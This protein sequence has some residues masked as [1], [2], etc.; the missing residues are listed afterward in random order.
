MKFKNMFFLLSTP[1]IPVIALTSCS[2]VDENA[3][4]KLETTVFAAKNESSF[5]NIFNLLDDQ[6]KIENSFIEKNTEQINSS[7]QKTIDTDKKIQ[8][9]LRIFFFKSIYDS[10]YS[11]ENIIDGVLKPQE[12][13]GDRLKAIE[14][15]KKFIIKSSDENNKFKLLEDELL[16]IVDMKL[17]L[18]QK[19]EGEIQSSWVWEMEFRLAENS[20]LAKIIQG[21]IDPTINKR[22]VFYKRENL[23]EEEI[24]FARAAASKLVPNTTTEEDKL[25]WKEAYDTEI[26]QAQYQSSKWYW[27]ND[28]KIMKTIKLESNI[29]PYSKDGTFGGFSDSDSKRTLFGIDFKQSANN[30]NLYKPTLLFQSKTV[31][32]SYINSDWRKFLE[33][34][35]YLSSSESNNTSEADEEKAKD[36]IFDLNCAN[37]KYDK[38]I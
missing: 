19:N 6:N 24:I 33:Y 14:E 10:L 29:N 8:E 21:N 17:I 28:T 20:E 31:V 25:K 2:A 7:V 32:E 38:K 22:G 13:F 12:A 30:F 16:K 36:I 27:N 34:K 35:Q 3:P 37:V 23:S 11:V 9:K 5:N 15:I 26:L 4:V 18:S 1:I